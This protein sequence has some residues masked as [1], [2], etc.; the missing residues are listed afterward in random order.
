MTA[1][2]ASETACRHLMTCIR[3]MWDICV[4]VSALV[5]GCEISGLNILIRNSIYELV[6]LRLFLSC[7]TMFVY[8]IAQVT[9]HAHERLINVNNDV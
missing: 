9:W 5:C 8:L 4:D 6:T 2:M 1:D 3:T 7:G